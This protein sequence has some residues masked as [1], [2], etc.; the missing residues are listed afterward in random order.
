MSRP[1]P[2]PALKRAEDGTVH[3]AAPRVSPEQHLH[4]VP[5]A[6]A[7]ARAPGASSTA[8]PIEHDETVAE[9]T[10]KPVEL[11]AMVPKDLR[12]EVRHRAQREGR[13]V[14]AVVTEALARYVTG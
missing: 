14:D 5:H 8:R 3:P 13:S 2:R 7:A 12:K 9:F 6:P 11:A 1:E 10:G 4:P